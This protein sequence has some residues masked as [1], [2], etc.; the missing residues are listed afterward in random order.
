MDHRPAEP[1]HAR[2]TRDLSA[3][4]LR[5]GIALARSGGPDA[6]SLRD[7]QRRAGVSNS[8]AYRHFTDRAALMAAISD[9]AADEMAIRMRSALAAVPDPGD[10]AERARARLRASG[11]AYLD[12]ALTEPGLFRVAFQTH[13]AGNS[14]RLEDPADCPPF[15]VLA[16]CLDDL[17]DSGTLN[18]AH[19]PST[20]YAAWAAVHGL[21]VLLLDG[22][23]QQLPVDGRTAAIDRL[24][25]VID[26]G[27]R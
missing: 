9:Y 20:D 8:A 19:R 3:M 11:A 14:T 18:P 17:V 24:I 16:G 2:P 23:L 13:S 27:T 10:G 4:L 21:A 7:V 25:T 12:F 22:P 1:H 15:R 26:D 6:V 5:E